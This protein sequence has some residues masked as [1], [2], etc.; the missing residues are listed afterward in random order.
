MS[1]YE[2]DQLIAFFSPAGPLIRLLQ[3]LSKES[4]SICEFPVD[5]L[6]ACVRES[7][8]QTVIPAFYM[9]KYL[10]HSSCLHLKPVDYFWFAFFYYLKTD[11]M[12]SMF[13]L[14]MGNSLNTAIVSIFEAYLT[15]FV[16]ATTESKPANT[17]SMSSNSI[18]ESLSSTTSNL[19]HL[20]SPTASPLPALGA[21]PARPSLINAKQFQLT[22]NQFTP[23]T[24]DDADSA[25]NQKV[26]CQA[27]I[28]VFAE[29]LLS[30]PV[31]RATPQRMSPLSMRSH[32]QPTSDQVR[33]VRTVIKHLHAFAN[34]CPSAESMKDPQFRFTSSPLDE[35]KRSVWSS[36]MN[37]Q[38]R[39]CNY[40]KFCFET[41]PSDASFRMPVETWLSYI[42]PWRYKL[43]ST[44]GRDADD[45]DDHKSDETVGKEWLTFISNNLPFYNSM[46][47]QV[48]TRLS[49]FDLTSSKNS[50]I[51]FRVM[52]VFAASKLFLLVREAELHASDKSSAIRS[53]NTSRKSFP[54]ARS[55]QSDATLIKQSFQE[56]EELES[57]STPLFSEK[58]LHA[59]R[60]L[61]SHMRV[62]R[63]IVAQELRTIRSSC[64]QAKQSG[65]LMNFIR[66]LFEEETEDQ[67]DA[68]KNISEWKRTESHLN[69]SLMR[70]ESIFGIDAFASLCEEADQ[71]DCEIRQRHLSSPSSAKKQTP[72]VILSPDGTPV[73]SPAGRAQLRNR[74]AK[75]NVTFD[76]NPDEQRTRSYEIEFLVKSLLILSAMINARI[77][78]FLQQHYSSGSLLSKMLHM[79]LAPPVSYTAVSKDSPLGECR[80]R[81]HHLPARVCLRRLADQ[82]VICLI[83]LLFCF[84]S[85]CGISLTSLTLYSVM[86]WMMFAVV[87]FMCD[88][89]KNW[90]SS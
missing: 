41:W 9:N 63:E 18:W 67:D 71:V 80:R 55:P 77:G 65:G 28:S 87:S 74:L 6:P 81:Q 30:V 83:L 68:G 45:D 34:S 88:K 54:A 38:N 46:F 39:L 37:L 27:F 29:M 35:M 25:R 52:K 82:R 31:T 85:L 40:L 36:D 2:Y 90:S 78:P 61:Y 14:E 60:E 10:S 53:P 12:G 4:I 86:L 73:L 59:V 19:L 62:S 76:G 79:L 64:G 47:L 49:R 22:S 21:G 58:S 69:S 13:L 23:A 16:P 17:E 24:G 32:S 50:I 66:S 3:S 43:H 1:A 11:S 7:L 26:M 8:D 5:R 75:S 44:T 84:I 33:F 15:H 20:K 72:D 51:I 89:L 70:L 48:A 56:S 57:E 42:Q